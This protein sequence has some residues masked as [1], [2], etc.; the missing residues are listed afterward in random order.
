M[1]IPSLETLN[2]LDMDGLLRYINKVD[3]SDFMGNAGKEHYRLL[4]WL[5]HQWDGETLIDIGTHK[6]S[7][8]VAL[9]HNERNRVLS[10]DIENR[11]NPSLPKRD[12]VDYILHDLMEEGDTPSEWMTEVLRSPLILLDIDP[13]EGTR[14]LKFVKYLSDHKYSGILICDD[15][16]HFEDMKNNFWSKVDTSKKYDVTHLGHWSGTGVVDFREQKDI[17]PREKDDWTLVTAYFDL[18]RL[19]DG[20]RSRTREH[21]MKSCAGTF[22]TN[23]NLVVFCE[24]DMVDYFKSMRPIE[25]MPKTKFI[26]SKWEDL[27]LT[28]NRAKIEENRRSHPYNF[29]PRNTPNYYLFCMSR[30][31]MLQEVIESNPFNST[32]FAWINVCMERMGPRNLASLDEALELHRDKFSCLFINYIPRNI[33]RD[34][35]VYYQYG[36]CTMC[37]GF[38]TGSKHYMSEFCARIIDEFHRM[39]DL[40]HG[41]ADEQ[42]FA[43]VHD[44]HP[45]LFE[46]YYGTY[47]QM[48]TN[49]CGVREAPH[50]VY[51]HLIPSSFR[52]GAYDVT[53]AA[54]RALWEGHRRREIQVHLPNLAYAF[55]SYLASALHLGKN[56]EA[57]R[58]VRDISYMCTESDFLGTVTGWN[59]CA[60]LKLS[61]K[62]LPFLP[63]REIKIFRNRPHEAD[64]IEDALSDGKRVVICN[65]NA[66]ISSESFATRNPIVRPARL[67]GGI[68]DN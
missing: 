40:G 54:A 27:P 65:D 50:E 22:R 2:N 3:E 48:I 67:L 19:E 23:R 34:P 25:L 16:H 11:V 47:Q 20:D 58:I 61:D 39:L 32:H 26:V 14:E 24:E 10:F 4:A 63:K 36:R 33:L 57:V 53:Y 68:L 31:T 55:Y 45:E 7:S 62:V 29:D 17:V 60:I 28:A 8:S 38:F 5:S 13:H 15:V 46:H 18:S 42:L 59:D 49:Y 44:S 6:G 30:Y 12:N 52:E 64:D 43:L 51:L 66:V 35:P 41:H 9:S 21:Y 37:S 1:Q 56:E